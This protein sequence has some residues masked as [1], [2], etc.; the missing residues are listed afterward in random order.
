MKIRLALIAIAFSIASWAGTV[1]QAL[2]GFPFQD[3][4]L[5]FQVK[6]PTGVSLGEGRMQAR[7]LAGGGWE[8]DLSLDASIPGFALSDHYKSS[9]TADLC[10]REFSRESTH[11]AKKSHESV[12]FT[13]EQRTAHRATSGGGASDFT[14]PACAMDALSYLYF[15]RREMGQGRV[16]PAGPIVFGGSYDIR[17]EYKGEET[18]KGAVTDRV[19]ATV[20][21]PS[22]NVNFDVLFARDPARS[23][24][25]IRLPLALGT[26][27]LEL[28]R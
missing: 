25:L 17:L 4:T 18:F 3:E 27:S 13:Q 5:R 19:A 28:T 7:R 21:G 6:W 8:F 11:G 16:P 24:V 12:T 14:V 20:R 10:S 2:T 26:F 22:S 9:A 15:T 23:P 1:T